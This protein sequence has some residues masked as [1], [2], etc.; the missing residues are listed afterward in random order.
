MRVAVMS[1]K[2]G[3]GKTTIAVALAYELARRGHRV[4]LLDLDFHG[5]TLPKIA[6]VEEKA[7]SDVNCIHP[8]ERDGLKIF[9]IQYIL[10]E[11]DDPVLWPGD[12]KRDVV[13]QLVEGT[14]ICWGD[15]DVMVVDSPPSLG[16]ENLELLTH[17]DHVVVVTT[18]H[19]ASIHDVRK[20]VKALTRIGKKPLAIV[21]NMA[22]IFE[23]EVP[24]LGIPVI[25]IPFVKEL[26]RDPRKPRDEIK[27][28]ADIVE[29]AMEVSGQ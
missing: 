1:N 8:V 7:R 17:V 2:G 26:Q 21:V 13:S 29:K 16:D 3:V 5:P 4:A 27:T 28:L 6:G 18:P 23:G 10:R 24:E 9:S 12:V 19:P 20:L 11:D 14:S 22:D 25:K 15:Y